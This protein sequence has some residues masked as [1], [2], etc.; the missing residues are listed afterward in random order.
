M[1]HKIFSIFLIVAFVSAISSCQT[2]PEEHKGAAV[3]AGVGAATGAATGAVLGKSTKAA[4]IGGL[5]E[6][7]N[8]K[9]TKE[10]NFTIL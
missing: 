6:A 9:D 2:V 7:E 1:K 10:M 3:G 8:V 5:V 4:V